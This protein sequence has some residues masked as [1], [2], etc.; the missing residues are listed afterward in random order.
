MYSSVRLPRFGHDT[1]TAANSSCCQPTPIP[2]SK[3]PPD[4]QSTLATS[5]A[6]YTGLRCGRSRIPVPRRMVDVCPARKARVDS[7]SRIPESAVAGK[8]PFSSYG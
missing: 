3:R 1:L 5:F 6:V 2:R 4:S 7:G 8:R